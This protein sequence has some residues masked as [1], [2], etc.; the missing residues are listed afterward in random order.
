[1]G[2]DE[3]VFAA[4]LAEGL[5]LIDRLDGVRKDTRLLEQRKEELA[6]F[7]R[8]NPAFMKALGRRNS[9]PGVKDPRIEQFRVSVMPVI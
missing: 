3:K 2:L 5:R 8:M 6:S 1:M 7:V 9:G 4:K